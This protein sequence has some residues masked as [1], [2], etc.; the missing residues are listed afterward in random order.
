M[1]VKRMFKRVRE[2]LEAQRQ[3]E[4]LPGTAIDTQPVQ[5]TKEQS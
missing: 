3:A 4:A 2:Q 1:V 5:P